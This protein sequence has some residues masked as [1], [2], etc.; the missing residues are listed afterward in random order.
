MRFESEGYEYKK[1]VTPDLSDKAFRIGDGRISG[2]LSMFLG[3][4]SLL[5]VLAYQYPSYLTT[6]DLRAAYD[7]EFLQDVLMYCMWISLGFGLLT[8]ILNKRKRMGAT[9]VLC[10]LLAFAL[11][12]YHIPTGPVEPSQLSFGLDWLLLAFVASAAVFIFIEK[13]FPKYREQIITRPEWK[14][15]MIYFI[16][17]H[18]LITV[19]LLVANYFFTK[20]FSW[21]ISAD[22]QAFVQSQPLWLQVIMLVLA[23]DF[24]LYW[25]HRLYHEVPS[26]WNIHAVHHSVEYMDW[27]A[28]SR[29]HIVQT[30]SDRIIAIV[31]LY[32]IGPDKAAL[33]IYVSFAAFQAVYVHANVNIPL[34]PLQYILVTPKFH[35]WHHSS[36][37]PAIDTNYSVH[38]PLFDKL[39]NTYHMPKEH[40]P[41][42]YGTV[43]R[44][45]RTFFQQL[46]YPFSK[47]NKK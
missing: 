1:R 34:G 47:G 45:P 16:V 35:H 41:S 42:H 11:G 36:Q 17:N 19:L 26:L 10:T 21:A 8:F 22:L 13:V 28:G 2:Y 39:F 25:S 18:L 46:F 38:T 9:G 33:D 20:V 44:I 23:A 29:N 27:L 3:I 37:K 4:I 6:A 15:D 14:L 40:W 24:V 5:A 31:P 30:F 7:A 43:P 12:G 32:L